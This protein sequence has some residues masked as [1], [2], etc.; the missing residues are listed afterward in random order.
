VRQRLLPGLMIA[1]ALVFGSS[2]NATEP[3]GRVAFRYTWPDGKD[4]EAPRLRLSMTAVVALTGAR[5]V[6][7]LPPGVGVSLHDAAGGGWP[8]AG[9]DLGTFAAGRTVVVEFDIAKPERG[10]GIVSFVLAATSDGRAVTEGVGVPVGLPG[11]EPTLRNGA[12]EFPASKPDAT[13]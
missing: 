13:P 1:A 5:L 10:G 4:G 2:A 3:D 6:A 7:K 8:D 11:T 9:L 12:V